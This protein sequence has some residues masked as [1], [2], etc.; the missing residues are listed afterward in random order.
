MLFHGLTKS[1][2]FATT[3]LSVLLCLLGVINHYMIAIR[4]KALLPWEIFA[5]TTAENLAGSVKLELDLPLVCTIIVVLIMCVIS[6]LLRKTVL[7]KN[8]RYATFFAGLLILAALWGILWNAPKSI[9]SDPWYTVDASRQN[10]MAVNLIHN[11]KT[12][13]NAAPEGYS[14][15]RVREIIGTQTKETEMTPDIVV[16]MDE[17]FADL[18]Q[19]ADLQSEQDY[20]PFIHSLT[21]NTISGNARVSVFGGGTCNTEYEFLTGNAVPML[22]P[23]SYPMVQFV[24]D[25]APSVAKTLK[26]AGYRTI[27]LH[28][29]YPD[30]WN[31]DIAYPRLGFD[32]FYCNHDFENPEMVREYISDSASFDKIIDLLEENDT[33]A[34]IFNV[35]MQNHFGYERAFDN[36][37]EDAVFPEMNEFPQAKRYFSLI[38]LTDNAVRELITYLQSREKPT[39]LLFFGDHL[40]S[41]EEEYYDILKQRAGIS[42]DEMDIKKHTVPFFIWANYDIEEQSGINISSSFLAPLLLDVAG[43]PMTEHQTY[44]RR[45]MQE[46]PIWEEGEG[47]LLNEYHMVQYNMVFDKFGKQGELFE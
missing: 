40:P 42:D 20:I 30:G 3:I 22:R 27:G 21:E 4:A 11:T 23:G 8:A 46:M 29:F 37:T 32:K 36:L 16:V 10:G 7:F 6:W 47:E 14:T 35:T 24:K 12:M 2:F 41:I 43:V 38:S 39:I 26:A 31:R 34:F 9:S 5:L 15:A 18:S 28:S 45:L 33:P 44:L 17:S 13:I 1:L 25:G 19:I